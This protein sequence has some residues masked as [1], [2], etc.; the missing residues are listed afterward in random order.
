MPFERL[1]RARKKTVGTKQTI[2]AVQ[3]GQAKVVYVARDADAHV[4]EPVIRACRENNIPLIQVESMRELGR[5]CG[6]AV[7]CASASITEE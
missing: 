1:K 3:K 4:V 5:V 6:I 2:K 7:G